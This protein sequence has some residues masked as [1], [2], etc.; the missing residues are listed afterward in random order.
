VSELNKE[1]KY[2]KG[3][4]EARARLFKKLGVVTLR[5]LL[6][7]FPRDYEDRT[8][9]KKIAELSDGESVTVRA[10]AS[11][12]PRLTR[13]T[14][15]SEIALLRVYD[16][17]GMMNVRF[18]NQSYV[19]DA[20]SAGETYLFYG[21]IL[22]AGGAALMT[23]PVFERDG[24]GNPV[25]IGRVTPIYRMT[26]GLNMRSVSNA[27]ALA[28][29][30][31]GDAVPDSLPR[32]V[33]EEYGLAAARFA[34]ENIHFPKDFESLK[35]ARRRLI[36]ED[37]FVLSVTAR[38]RR[39]ER[40]SSSGQAII[41]EGFGEFYSALPF[42]PTAA[43]KRAVDEAARD[44]ASGGVMARML[45]GD[46]GSGKTLVAA[47][48]AWTVAKNGFQ[49]AFMAPT[50]LLAEQHFRTFED[51]LSPLGVRVGRLT[52]SLGVK[53]KRLAREAL[54]SGETDVIVGTHALLS[55]GVDFRALALVIT[56]EQ[57]RFGVGQRAALGQ[58]GESPHVL[59]MSATPIP[60]TL[61]LILYGDL[62]VSEL[63]ELPPGRKSVMTYSAGERLRR[64]IYDFARRLVSEGRQVYFVCPA[65]E[66]ADMPGTGGEGIEV[67]SPGT[68]DLG[69]D[70]K[71]AR[72]Y[73]KQLQSEIFP[74]LSVGLVHG[75]MKAREKDAAMASFISGETDILV[76]TTVIEVGVDVPNAALIVIEN[77]DRFGLSQL[78]QLRGR[79]GR[80]EHQ[81]YCVLMRGADGE[82]SRERLDIL[83][84]TNDGF[85]IA[86][87]DLRQRGPGDFFGSRQHGIPA[88]RFIEQGA[89]A[90]TVWDARRA[91][92]TVLARDPGLKLRENRALRE[93]VDA[94]FLASD[95]TFN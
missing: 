59:V 23:N 27:V 91:A 69:A 94:I 92:D 12:S 75:S 86:E 20:I 10:V 36:F 63:N 76:A 53:A 46:V 85:E 52:G 24:D 66:E 62:D 57:H 73:A 40:G 70:L 28:L 17:T 80:G 55:E 5:E 84:G 22:R 49:T 34:Y 42:E 43:Q 31:C 71:R 82:K 45:Q 95:G 89:E 65:V 68:G 54:V 18:F 50:E 32:S 44:L 6:R 58:K 88:S 38:R 15:G 11:D 67:R 81:S 48:L 64:R 56:D 39:A 47:A 61:A 21:K 29:K 87:A 93:A 37:L 26:A 14:R 72:E 4:G 60:R 1:I 78:H 51:F 25:K 74:E 2:L 83:R 41:S 33:R 9:F 79:V 77:A 35:I 7:Y 16:D 30:L 90:G 19:K 8:V 3:V 13:T